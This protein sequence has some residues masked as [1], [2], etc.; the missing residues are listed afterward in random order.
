MADAWP[1]SIPQ[2]PALPANISMPWNVELA[3]FDVG[4]PQSR[5]VT[6][7]NVEQ[8]DPGSIVLADSTQLATFRTFFETT[9]AGGSLP[10]ETTYFGAT[11]EMKFTEAPQITELGA[12]RYRLQMSL[13]VL[14]T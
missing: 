12:D 3:Q 6:T 2:I 13:V 10:F 11:R 4:P 7:A 1:A 14:P 5:L 8:F 9:L